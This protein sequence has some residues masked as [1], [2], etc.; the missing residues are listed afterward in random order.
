MATDVLN[1][2]GLYQTLNANLMTTTGLSMF[3]RMQ[4]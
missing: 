2:I 4:A 3:H 1:W